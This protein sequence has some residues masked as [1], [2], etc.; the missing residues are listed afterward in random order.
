[1]TNATTHTDP[2]ITTGAIVRTEVLVIGSGAGGAISAATLAARGYEV[3]VLEEGPFL[4][5]STIASNSPEAIAR[6]YRN[7]GLTPILGNQTIAYVEGRCVGGSTEVNSAFWHRLPQDSYYRWRTD[8]LLHDFTPE[9]MEPYFAMLERD[10]SVSYLDAEQAPKS[11]A[12]FRRGIDALHWQYQEV[13]RCQ[14]HN[15]GASPF[16]PGN[17][18]SMQRTYIPKALAAGARLIADCKVSKIVHRDG[19]ATGVHASVKQN[20]SVQRF[21]VHADLIFV[22]GGAVQTPAL[23]RRSGITK[24]V[25][26]NLCIHPMIKAAAL[27]DDEI[28]A[29]E[30]ALPIYQVKEFW[31]TITIG[32]AVFTPGF[33]AML[34]SDNWKTTQ[35][36]MPDWSRMALYYAASRGMNRGQIR[37]LPGLADGVV[38]RYQ[39]SEGDQQNISAG[40]AHLGEILFAAGAKAVYPSLRGQPVLKSA[41]QCRGWLKQ[42]IAINTMALSTVH[43]FSSCPMGENPDVCATDSF[44]RV[45]GFRNLHINDASLIPDS[46]GVNPQ[47]TTMAIALRNL[48][49]L[50]SERGRRV[51]GKL[52]A[53]KL[54]AAAPAYIITGASGWLGMRLVEVLTRGLP[55]VA[56]FAEPIAQ[57]ALRCLVHPNDNAT[58][59]S[60]MAETIEVVPVDLTDAGAVRAAFSD[61]AG[62]TVI[63][64]AGVIH[65][66][67]GVKEFTS[68]NVD[69]TRH[70]L[71]AAEDAAVR[72]FVAVSSNSPF[73]FNPHTDHLFDEQSPYNPYMGYGRSKVEMEGLV[74]AAHARGK[75]ET[76]IIRPPWFYGPHQPP[77]QTLFFKMIKDGRFPILGD[78]T[79][80]RSMAYVDNICQGLLLAATVERANGEVY[81]IAD[82][83]PYTI[84][85]IVDTVQEV[86]TTNFGIACASR[87]LKL[88]ALAGEIARLGDGTLQAIGI[89]NQKLHVLSEMGHTIACSIEKAKRELGYAPAVS[90]RDGMLRSIE[91]CLENGLRF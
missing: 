89:Y 20:G 48:D 55:G 33:L 54:P 27:F 21:E 42:P 2:P 26:D 1:M 41:D 64:I 72:R 8:A 84:N 80:K 49:H 61:A 29:H 14:K 13:P 38:V 16:A 62:A 24:N 30:E 74:K 23:L 39:L 5:T 56:R 3:L 15:A 4:D 9:V 19:R 90:L 87:R 85:E 76:V 86:L 12:L 66:T 88:P 75:L 82:A 18:Q 65:P 32:G 52:H 57:Q 22:C 6:L 35:Q 77:R 11:S 81:W 31:P 60:N 91:W 34:L 63:H 43:A 25:G 47:G 58:A 79:Q 46:P 36:A 68:V 44:G 78:G 10:L 73:G 51:R 71:E 37:V 83:R 59:L 69:G 67:R 28:G 17:K 53:V 45:N 7:G 70:L 40:L 50:D